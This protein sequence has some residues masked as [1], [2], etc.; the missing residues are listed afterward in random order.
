MQFGFVFGKEALGRITQNC[1]N[2]FI[3]F[4][5]EQIICHTEMIG[6]LKCMTKILE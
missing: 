3:I 5:R 6:G 4:R 2:V 1:V